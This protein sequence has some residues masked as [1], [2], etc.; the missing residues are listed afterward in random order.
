MHFSGHF[1]FGIEARNIT[2][3]ISG[4]K[5]IVEEGK[6]VTVNEKAIYNESRIQAK[7]LWERMD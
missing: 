2:H 6:M 5:L 3:V 1:L 7:R 4:G